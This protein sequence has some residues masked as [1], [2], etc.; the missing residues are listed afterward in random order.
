MKS[1]RVLLVSDTHLCHIPWYGVSTEERLERLNRQ[2][3]EEY[4]EDPYSM[5]LFLGDYSLDFWAYWEQ[6]DVD[7]AFIRTGTCHAGEYL[8]RFA[9]KLPV[10][11]WA[12][13]GNH[14]QYTA[15]QWKAISGF[16]RQFHVV[17]DDCVFVLHD[18][19]AADLGPDHDT[20]GTFTP[21][22]T[23]YIRGLMERYPG[24]RFVLC[25]HHFDPEKESEEGK[26]L[27]RE[28]QIVM[29]F[30]G[31]THRSSV[32]SLSPECG[33]KM[34]AQTGNYSYSSEKDPAD[35]MW[36]YRDL[37]IEG[38][39]FVSRYIVPANTYFMD[40]QKRTIEKHIQDTVCVT[41][42]R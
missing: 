13:C 34:L 20:D 36:G 22:D 9:K 35:S 38:P 8:D 30:S 26:K 10:P 14:E 32:I 4:R 25:G 28:K 15:G 2:L 42:D 18:S 24:Y 12:I 23:G 16:D 5:I 21:L 7:E 3:W 6:S 1:K 33:G 31:H 27:L 29:L 17:L 37:R 19:Y 39:C 40:G 41:C 11:Y